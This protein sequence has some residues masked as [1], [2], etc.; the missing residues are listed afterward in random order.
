MCGL[1]SRAG[2]N[3]ALAWFVAAGWEARGGAA[4]ADRGAM[5]MRVRLARDRLSSDPSLLLLQPSEIRKGP[6]LPLGVLWLRRVALGS[7]A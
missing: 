7:V 2:L 6:S 1:S 5:R 3:K 4:E